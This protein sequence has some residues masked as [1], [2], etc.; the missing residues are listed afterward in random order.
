MKGNIT[1]R[2][3]NSW[4]LKFDAGRDEKGER[5]TQFVTFRGTKREAQV[6]MAEMIASVAQST[7]VEPS[8]VT[9]AEWVRG[10]V[11]HWET[12]GEISARTAQRYRQLTEHQI[13]PHIGDKL[14]QRLK[15]ADIE[16][17]HDTLRT[18]GRVRGKG[19]LSART[20]GHAHRVLGKALGEAVK[21]GHVVKNV[22]ALESAPKVPDEEMEIVQ[23]VPAFV[24][25]MRGHRLFAMGMVGLFTGMRLGEVLALR[26]GR[27]DLDRKV[28]QVREALEETKAHGIR[29][30]A[31][32]SKAGRRDLSLPDLLVDA[33]RDFRR[34]Q[35]ELRLK[36]GSGKLPDDGLLFGNLE[37]EPR[38]PSSASRA[39][40]DA[41]GVGYHNLRHTHASQLIDGD[42]DIVTISKRLGHA[43][44]DITLRIY[45]HMFKKTDA[46]AA[47]AINAALR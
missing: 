47:A 5:K 32:K 17:W 18:G 14:L 13:A 22:V 7:F 38:S 12:S 24:E 8:K 3:K 26:W 44:P 42:V 9:V 15:P 20:I 6:K 1:R 31:P 29:F 34:E 28:I 40:G 21:H 30:K 25:K 10:R 36:L 19:D 43:K 41:T 35:L 4:R 16:T 46:K 2:G 11:D 27:V 45:A 23:D 39:W 37:G 33:L